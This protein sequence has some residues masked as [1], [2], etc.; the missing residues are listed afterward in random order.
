MGHRWYYSDFSRWHCYLFRYLF[1]EKYQAVN[2]DP[3]S[4]QV[5]ANL[6][7]ADRS[8]IPV[9]TYESP[10]TLEEVQ[11]AIDSGGKTEHLAV[12]A[13]ALNSTKQQKPSWG[14]IYAVY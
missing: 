4:V 9:P 13:L 2:V 6:V 5:F 14:K 8:S 11:R 10:F 12:T 3:E 1:Q 7:R